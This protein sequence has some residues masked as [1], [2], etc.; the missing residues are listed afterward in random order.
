MPD[1]RP[2]RAYRYNLKKV[3]ELGNVISPPYDVISL[4]LQKELYSRSPYN[5]VRLT[6]GK[7]NSSDNKGNNRYTRARDFLEKWIKE[8][9]FL[10]DSSDSFYIYT[11]KF[12][13]R[14]TLKTRNGFF[15]LLRMDNSVLPHENTMQKPKEDRLELLR[16]T[17]TNL[18]PIFCLY[19]DKNRQIDSIIKKHLK[20]P[21][22]YA[23]DDDVEH[24]MYILNQE[25]DIKR[26]R[27]IIA[28]QKILIAD[29]HHRYQTAVA[30]WM[31]RGSKE[32]APEQFVLSYFTDMNDNALQLL[33]IHRI[34]KGVKFDQSTISKISKWFYV[35]E[36]LSIDEILALLENSYRTSVYGIITK[37]KIYFL[38]LKDRKFSDTITL[39]SKTPEWKNLDVAIL[40]YGIL[41]LFKRSNIEVECRDSVEECM[42]KVKLGGFDFVVLLQPTKIEQVKRIAFAGGKMPRKS[43]FFYPKPVSGLVIRKLQ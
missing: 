41:H 24:K 40:E 34:V 11:E 36:G 30:Y 42:Q 6:L 9:I 8:K 2:F 28:P 23:K 17:K 27:Q 20:K 13:S 14:N 31:E 19:S 10:E 18:E 35:R 5:I 26:I 39:K 37:E 12:R 1:I 22:S 16:H 25:Q 7:I 29:G 38:R 43:T 21:V 32:N 15:A 4:N 33:P 3:K